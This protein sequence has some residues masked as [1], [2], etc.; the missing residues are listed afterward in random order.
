M[1]NASVMIITIMDYNNLTEK[2]QLTNW[3]GSICSR[4]F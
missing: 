2:L 1:Q 4:D 3:N